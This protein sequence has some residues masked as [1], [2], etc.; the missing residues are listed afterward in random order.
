MTFSLLNTRS[1]RKYAIDITSDSDLTESDAFFFNRNTI[2]D[3]DKNIHD[4]LN[5]FSIAFNNNNFC[6]SSLAIA[7]RSSVLIC[8]N[9]G[10]DDISIM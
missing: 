1:S 10:S 3:N 2:A 8:S 7:C 5:D 9:G 4:L 6:I